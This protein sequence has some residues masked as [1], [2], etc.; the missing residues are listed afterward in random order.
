MAALIL[1]FLAATFLWLTL[2]RSPCSWDDGYYLT[3]SLVLYD[4]LADGGLPGYARRFVTILGIRPPL[5]ALLPTPVYLMVGRIPRAAYAVNL[6]FLLVMFAALHRLGKRFGSPKAGLLAVYIA[7]TMPLLY[8]LS[9]W[10]L[11]ECGLTAI[12]CVS[13]C[14]LAEWDD[15]AG[16]WKGFLLGVTFG[17]GLLMK[18]SFPL[19]VVIPVLYVAV[20]EH[21]TMLQRNT[22]LAFTAPAAALALPWYLFN[23]R[24]ALETAL[25]AGSADVGKVYGTGL[26]FSSTAIWNY[27]GNLFN[28]GPA[29]YFIALPV[30][31]FAAAS[32]VRPTQKRGL[33]LCALW[34]SPILVLVF[35]HYRDMRYAAP[36]F[37]AL[38]LALAILADPMSRGRGVARTALYGLLALPL[39]SMVQTSFAVLG[40]RRL[41]LGGLLFVAPKLSYARMY[42]P[43]RW[44]HQE[45]L[46]GIHQLARFTGSER[47]LLIVGTDSP[48]FNANNFELAA[49]G[50]KLPFQVAT[51][52]YE[53]D[54]SALVS[55]LDSTAYFVYKE[56][57]E[58]EAP[59]FNPL[60]SA[61]LKQVREGGRF[62]ELPMARK[63]PD[64]GVARVFANLGPN[65]FLRAGAFLSAGMNAVPDCNVTFAGK[66]QL[67]G[68]SFQPTAEGLEVKYRWR[69]LRPVDRNYWCFTHVVDR[70]G[71]VIGYL[72]HQILDGEPPLRMWKEG[73][74]AIERLLLRS[75]AIHSGE[76]YRLRLGLFDKESGKRL[77]VSSSEFPV[78]DQQ[79][80]AVIQPK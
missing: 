62:A 67:T 36:L 34:G 66:L 2:D 26:V 17:L 63:L 60:G 32:V 56:G 41:E 30:L 78:V 58:P 69:C 53:T 54:L 15:F 50:K 77:P 7:G 76:S 24:Q 48:H 47:K 52:A 3:N 22:L 37:P 39:C 42:H 75:P 38:A 79:T 46:S 59:F 13:I 8:G 23:Y 10:F 65:R 73:D 51:T 19:Y 49:V 12:V 40:D 1:F 57:G 25:R 72:D 14:L 6:V 74:L 20:R 28:A 71:N 4:A 27:L 16:A 33:L 68:L 45:I 43:D 18:A 55:T 9:R 5:I 61:A 35:S 11:V 21:R 70:G 64:G 44:P 29:L 80:A 31:V